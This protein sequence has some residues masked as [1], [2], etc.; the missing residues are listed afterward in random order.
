MKGTKINAK[1][2]WAKKYRKYLIIRKQYIKN[3]FMCCPLQIEL[4]HPNVGTKEWTKEKGK[5]GIKKQHIF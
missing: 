5:N 3:I 2:L 4:I 1:K